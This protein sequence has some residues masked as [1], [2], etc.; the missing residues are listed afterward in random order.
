MKKL[1]V[2][3]LVLIQLVLLSAC[4]SSEPNSDKLQ[5]Y[6]SFYAMYDFAK[7]IGGDKTDIYLLCPSGQEPHDFEPTARDIAKLS[8]ADIFIYNGMGME[9]WTDSVTATLGDDVAIVKT[10]DNVRLNKFTAGDPHVWLNPD[11]AYIQL[12]AIADAFMEKDPANRDY[13]NKNLKE[14]K[15]KIKRLMQDLESA[16]KMFSSHSIVVSH[17]A[18]SHLCD[19]IDIS[20]YAV[21]GTD[22]SGDPTP[23]RMAEIENYIKSN[24]IKYIFTE[25]MGTSDIMKTIAKDT[26]CEILVLDP[27]E[28]SSENKDY[29][30]VM[31]ENIAALTQALN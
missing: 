19:V 7:Q 18:Y 2:F 29:F 10:T 27:F 31:Y 13:Y 25:P 3:I 12:K 23:Q 14:C 1:S 28:G 30:K 22:N 16:K 26:N 21:N 5:V 8:E 15:E 17:Y 20:P 9:H 4:Q 6:T 11:N 24:D